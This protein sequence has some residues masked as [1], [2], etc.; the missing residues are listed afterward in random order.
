MQTKPHNL[1][2]RG[3]LQEK[4]IFVTDQFTDGISPSDIENLFDPKDY[5]H[6]YNSAFG[7]K[8]TKTAVP[9]KDRIIAR[10][11]RSVG[12]PFVDHGAPADYLLRHRQVQLPKLSDVTL[13]LFENLFKAINKTL[14]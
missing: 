7:A 14:T 11:S 3:L 8:L 2:D 12:S 9:G 10:I 1:A 5:F 13:E 4:R 6:L